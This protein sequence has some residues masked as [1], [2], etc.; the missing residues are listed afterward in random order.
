MDRKT[1]IK[2]AAG[3]ML[4]GIPIYSYLSCSGSDD[5]PVPAGADKNCLQNGTVGS[6]SANHGHSIT[7]SKADVNAGMEKQYNIISREP[8]LIIMLLPFQKVTLPR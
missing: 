6:V 2:K 4:I 7:V 3:T 1:F 5:A 8:P